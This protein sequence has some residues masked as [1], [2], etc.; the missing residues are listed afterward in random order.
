MIN[1][2]KSIFLW[3]YILIEIHIFP[4]FFLDGL[5]FLKGFLPLLN[6]PPAT[7]CGPRQARLE[8]VFWTAAG[9]T[10]EQPAVR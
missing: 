2:D 8:Q 4:M 5:T 6:R 10:A 1:H 3:I 7:L 9:S